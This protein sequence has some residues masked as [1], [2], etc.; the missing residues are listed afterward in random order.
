MLGVLLVFDLLV[1]VYPG[2]LVFD[3]PFLTVGACR[4]LLL[5]LLDT[6]EE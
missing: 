3:L 4:L 5:L 1:F 2:L 6:E